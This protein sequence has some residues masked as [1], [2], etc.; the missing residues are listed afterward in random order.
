MRICFLLCAVI[1]ASS[2]SALLAQDYD[3]HPALSDNFLLS[4]G[5]FRSD[6]TFKIRAEGASDDMNNDEIDF[7]NSLS[8]DETNTIFNGQLR[9]KFGKE[10]KWSLWGQYFSNDAEGSATL[11]ED[12]AWEDVIFREGTFVEA[13]VEIE[14]IRLFVG[15][16]LVKNKQHDFGLGVGLHHLDLG[17][18]IGGEINIDDESTGF[19]RE[20]VSAGAPLPNLG[21]WYLFS[22]ARNWLLHARVD[23]LSVNIDPYDGTMWNF[24]A[25]V[26]FQAWR[27]VGFDLSYQYFDIDFGVDDDDFIG[28]AKM[29][30][31]GPILSITANW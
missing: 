28:G 25:G 31:S 13:G 24:N 17:A 16:S 2:S 5:A 6:N 9:W 26:N 23:W 14:V 1:L 18:F 27:N 3:Y 4:V 7:G 19:V 20:S 10:R 30:Y 15:R 8:V 11:T 21:A 12:V 22:P 29:S